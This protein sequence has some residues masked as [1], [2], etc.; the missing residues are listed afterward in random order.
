MDFFK[1]PSEV[2]APVPQSAHTVYQN[3]RVGNRIKIVRLEGGNF[4]H[5]KGYIGEVKDYKKDHPTA[6]IIVHA[7]NMPKLLRVPLEHFVIID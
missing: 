1:I 7:V 5:Y 2:P 4:N 6:L 3:I